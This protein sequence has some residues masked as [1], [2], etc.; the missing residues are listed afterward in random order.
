MNRRLFLAWPLGSAERRR[1]SAVMTRVIHGA[2]GVLRPVPEGS[3]HLT[4]VFLGER[5]VRTRELLAALRPLRGIPGFG[6]RF[7]GVRVFPESG[8]PRLV[9]L[10]VEQGSRELLS[11]AEA[12]RGLLEPLFVDLAGY[13]LK[14]PHVTLARFKRGSRRRDARAV[15]DLLESG[16]GACWEASDRVEKVTLV[17]SLLSHHGPSYE[18][19]AE[20]ALAES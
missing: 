9:C 11:L 14:P 18:T 4:V 13:R 17:R 20:I 19:L 10:R 1:I 15:E 6:I 7:R 12:V 5:E 8:R 3:E 2:G 16:G